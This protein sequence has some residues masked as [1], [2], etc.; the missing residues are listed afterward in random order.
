[1]ARIVLPPLRDRKQ[2]IP[3]LA[4]HYIKHFNGVFRRQVDSFAEEALQGLIQYDWPGNIRELRNFIKAVFIGRPDR[5]ISLANLASSCGAHLPDP[6]SATFSEP[7]K[8]VI[9][10]STT[11]WNKSKAAEKLQWSRMT[12]YRKVAKYQLEY[13]SAGA[14]PEKATTPIFFTTL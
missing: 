2:D 3:F 10:L 11:K 12:L 5:I 14:S 9:A 6:A 7:D 8:L 1:M 4:E 13:S